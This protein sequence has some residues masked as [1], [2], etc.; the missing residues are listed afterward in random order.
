MKT[1]YKQ[2]GYST[3]TAKEYVD[4]NKP[5]YLLSTELEEQYKFEDN[6][7]TDEITGYKAWF[8]QE[9]LPPF[10]VKFEN[11]VTLPKYMALIQFENL[12]GIEIR[13]NVYFKADDLSE[14]K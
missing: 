7:R 9:G 12:K 8:S 14:I 2:G 5:I 10:S 4:T 6:K 11:E 3:Q 1:R 13:Y